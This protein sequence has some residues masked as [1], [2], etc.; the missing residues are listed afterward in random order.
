MGLFLQ[1]ERGIEIEV[2]NILFFSVEVAKGRQNG[3]KSLKEAEK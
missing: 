3:C 2:S 1:W